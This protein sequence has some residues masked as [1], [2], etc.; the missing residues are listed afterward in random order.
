M[1]K[2]LYLFVFMVAGS[3]FGQDFSST[4]NTYLNSNRTELGLQSQDVEEVV[5]DRHSYSESMN[6]ENVYAIQQYQG[7]EIFNSIVP[8]NR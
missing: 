3:V 2:L 8:I 5:I 7:V 6:V 4:I 1:K